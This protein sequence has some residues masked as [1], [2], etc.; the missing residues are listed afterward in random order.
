MRQVVVD[1]PSLV[2]FILCPAVK[3]LLDAGVSVSISPAA[4]P[5]KATVIVPI[6]L[7][8]WFDTVT[9]ASAMVIAFRMTEETLV[10]VQALGITR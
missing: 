6:E 9:M 4:E 5:E 10:T 8:A 7:P 2:I 1:P 3:V